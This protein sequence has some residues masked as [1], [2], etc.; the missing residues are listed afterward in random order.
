MDVES[1]ALLHFAA[2][3]SIRVLFPLD[4]SWQCHVGRLANKPPRRTR[5]L[6]ALLLGLAA[7]TAN[8]QSQP[9]SLDD[10]LRDQLA[11]GD[12]NGCVDLLR[13]TDADIEAAGGPQEAVADELKRLAELG[14]IGNELRA[15]C[16]PSAVSSASS[17]GGALD[18]VQATKTVSQ[19]KLA[20]RRIDQRLPR[21]RPR[22]T[23]TSLMLMLQGEPQREISRYASEGYGVFGQIDYEW[24]E[25]DA[26][27]FEDGYK[28]HAQGGSLGFDF[29]W[30]RGIAGVWGGYSK[31]DADFRGGSAQAFSL[32]GEPDPD[33]DSLLSDPTVLSGVCGGVLPGGEFDLEGSRFGLFVSW[34]FGESAFLDFAASRSRLDYDY[35][36]DT[37]VIEAQG[38]ETLVFDD[39]VLFNDNPPGDGVFDPDTELRVDDI[40]AGTVSGDTTLTD[41][42]LSIRAGFDKDAGAWSFGPRATL[43]Y[44]RT[45]VDGYAETGSSTVAN[46]VSPVA[47]DLVERTLGGPLGLEL[48]YEDREEDATLL[49]IGGLVERHFEA[50]N[51][52]LIAHASAYWRHQFDDSRHFT[53]AQFVQDLRPTPTQFTFASNEIDSDNALFSLGVTALFAQRAAVRLEMT[54][55]AFDTLVDS[56]AV[57]LQFRVAL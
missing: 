43:Y 5:L 31:T 33:F 34:K 37:C 52:M 40:Y 39:T 35:A 14:Q 56:T 2:T 47:G 45:Q 17:L 24:R 30:D 13:V 36:R 9:L 20:R 1:R 28:G 4:T 21:R 27:R 29:A 8:A 22:P 51:D 15:I 48:A 44:L 6:G 49:E 53:T 57:S 25:R 19:F 11:L 3:V 54:H 10:Q 23:S 46:A 55:L 38:S 12:A 42:G 18:S 26:T 7:S 32:G 16:G 50:G 41:D